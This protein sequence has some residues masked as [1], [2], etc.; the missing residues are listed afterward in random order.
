M[1][2]SVEHLIEGRPSPVIITPDEPVSKALG[3]MIEYDFSQLPVT[4]AEQRPV[5][6][7]TYEGI[8]RGIRNFQAQISE[9]HV[10]D[11]MIAAPKFNL[12]DDL[13]ELLEKLKLA[14]AVL[15]AD[16]ASKLVGIVTS[17]DATEYFRNRA[18]NMMRVEDIEVMTKDFILLA[19]TRDD[20]EI[21]Q[22]KL[23]KAVSKVTSHER[24]QRPK[25]FADLSLG[26]YIDI[27]LSQ[28]KWSF[29]GPIFRISRTY[30]MKLLDSVRQTRNE[31]A[32][33]RNDITPEQVDQLQFC[34]QWLARRTE[35]YEQIG[36]PAGTSPDSVEKSATMTDEQD[37]D[38]MIAEETGPRESRYAPLADWL[39]SQ[40]G[41]KDQVELSFEQI[42]RIIGG[43][44]PLS[45]RQHRSWW[46]NDLQ[47]QPHSRMWLDVGWRR[48]RL[49]LTEEKVTFSRIKEREK[50]NIRFYSKLMAELRKEADFT[51]RDSS[52]DGTGW[53]VCKT[54]PETGTPIAQF[55]YSFGRDHRFRV[56]IYIDTGNQKTTKQIFDYVYER[57]E[58]IESKIRDVS[59]ERIDDKRASRIAIYRPGATGAI[60]DVTAEDEKHRELQEWGVERM[61]LLV[62]TFA[63]LIEAASEQVSR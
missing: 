45:A 42:E 60:M 22:A 40:S 36:Q 19:Y 48:R 55:S 47:S 44:L 20:G 57:K 51:V 11:V 61:I 18:E 27:L 35:E 25:G 2:F 63:P 17:F 14:N 32:H 56:E 15:I 16:T 50:A 39:N 30:L 3:M 53:I 38:E 62:K 33:F 9:L 24:D 49:N 29:Y 41:K 31:L 6:M 12:E 10:R 46:A 1:P 28:S 58:S 26:Q 4:D 7:V 59:W 13:F 21:D 37:L 8:L 43:E 52:P 34:A 23:D 54:I 5:G